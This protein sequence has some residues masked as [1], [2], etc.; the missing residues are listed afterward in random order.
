MDFQ[1][2]EAIVYKT[3]TQS[4]PIKNLVDPTVSDVTN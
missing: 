4:E 1:S 3:K 2:L